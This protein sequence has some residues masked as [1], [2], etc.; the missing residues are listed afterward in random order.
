[1]N[2]V[3]HTWWDFGY[4][5]I[6]GCVFLEQIGLPIPSFPMLLAAG[7][8]A[9]TGK[10][11]LTVCVLLAAVTAVAADS[12]WFRIGQVKGGKVLNFM[13]RLSWRPDTCVSKTKGLFTL[14][15]TKTL[16]FAKF[17]PGLST[18]A[19]PMAGMTAVPWRTFIIYDGIGAL[20]W[21]LVPLLVGCYLRDTL[22]S[23]QSQV[24]SIETI[25]PWFCGGLVVAVLIWHFIHRRR[26]LNQ[27]KRSLE[28]GISSDELK[29]AIDEGDDLV[30]LDIRD[31][32]DTQAQPVTLPNA[33]W[34]PHGVVPERIGELP[35]EKPIVVFCDCPKDQGAGDMVKVLVSYGAKR[36]RPLLGGLDG[37]VAKGFETVD[38]GSKI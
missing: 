10:L 11:S 2:S 4:L 13:C 23:M 8:F 6:V 16:L 35:L 30:L 21:A 29:R 17:I 20:S 25:L 36:V 22:K 3:T 12:I 9:A 27:L 19:P 26:Y 33:R 5:G 14:H 37:W 24:E 31:V 32:I 15:G 7:A 1:M 38:I 18:L 28:D 34:I